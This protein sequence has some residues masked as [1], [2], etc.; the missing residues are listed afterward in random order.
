MKITITPEEGESIKEI[1]Y[2]NVYQYA[3]CGVLVENKIIPR[4]FRWSVISDAN[5]L[6]GTL[7]SMELDILDHKNSK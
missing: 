5:E 2:E 7:K 6:I 3:I 1:V 4:H